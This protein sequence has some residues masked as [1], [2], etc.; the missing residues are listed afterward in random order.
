MKL[1]LRAKS[2]AGYETTLEE[3]CPDLG[4]V[5]DLAR[6]L[7]MHLARAGYTPTHP[8]PY[9]EKLTEFEQIRREYGG[10][11]RQRDGV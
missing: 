1:T 9:R 11:Q 4:A 2:P 5:L 8:R 3:D 6:D 7:E 10:Y